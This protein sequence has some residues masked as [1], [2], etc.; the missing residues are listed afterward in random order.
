MYSDSD[1]A[2]LSFLIGLAI[3]LPL[4]TIVGLLLSAT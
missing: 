1:I 4:A 3:A 2:V